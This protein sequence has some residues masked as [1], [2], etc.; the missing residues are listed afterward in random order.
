MP[1]KQ[2]TI[3]GFGEFSAPDDWTPQE[4]YAAAMNKNPAIREDFI[5]QRGEDTA[6][7][8]ETYAQKQQQARQIY[9]ERQEGSVPRLLSEWWGQGMSGLT[10]PVG[11]MG[12]SA[13]AFLHQTPLADTPVHQVLQGASERVHH[14]TRYPELYIDDASWL[15]KVARASYMPPD[16]HIQQVSDL[17]DVS[18][19]PPAMARMGGQV[20]ARIAV[21]TGVALAAKPLG[22]AAIPLVGKGA[23]ARIAAGRAT[24]AGVTALPSAASVA[25]QADRIARTASN[26]AGAGVLTSIVAPGMYDRFTAAGDDHER[27][28]TKTLVGA[29][30]VGSMDLLLGHSWRIAGMPSQAAREEAT[31]QL[32]GGALRGAPAEKLGRFKR[33]AMFDSQ[34]G[35]QRLG[36]QALRDSTVEMLQAFTEG[37]LEV[38]GLPTN[39]EEA[40][41]SATIS[42]LTSGTMLGGRMLATRE[43]R[44]TFLKSPHEIAQ[45]LATEEYSD[46]RRKFLAGEI[47]LQDAAKQTDTVL[48]W[49]DTVGDDVFTD[50]D[51]ASTDPS[52]RLRVLAEQDPTLAEALSDSLLDRFA[53]GELTQGRLWSAM[54]NMSEFRDASLAKFKQ[55]TG[56]RWMDQETFTNIKGMYAQ[57]KILTPAE[58]DM[59]FDPNRRLPDDWN[60]RLSTLF[61]NKE[62]GDARIESIKELLYHWAS[63]EQDHNYLEDPRGAVK[64]FV[65]DQGISLEVV[66]NTAAMHQQ[67]N[68]IASKTSEPQTAWYNPKTGRFRRTA[69]KKKK[70]EWKKTTISKL[71]EEH[72]YWHPAQNRAL[73]EAEARAIADK[74]EYTLEDLQSVPKAIRP[75]TM[76]EAVLY[77]NRNKTAYTTRAVAT[78]QEVLRPDRPIP[79]KGLREYNPLDPIRS[80]M[81]QYETGDKAQPLDPTDPAEFNS[82]QARDRRVRAVNSVLF[83]PTNS[84][85][86]ITDSSLEYMML[87]ST[88]RSRFGNSFDVADYKKFLV[89]LARDDGIRALQREIEMATPQI[90]VS[91]ASGIDVGALPYSSAS[92]SKAHTAKSIKA[93]DISAAAENSGYFELVIGYPDAAATE[94]PDMHQRAMLSSVQDALGETG[95]RDVTAARNAIAHVRGFVTQVNKDGEVFNVLHAEEVQGD[96]AKRWRE[97]K[98]TISE[99][100]A[101]LAQMSLPQ[102]QFIEKLEADLRSEFSNYTLRRGVDLDAFIRFAPE[103]YRP[104][105]DRINAAGHTHQAVLDSL[106]EALA[107]LKTLE[108]QI[109]NPLA[110]AFSRLSQLSFDLSLFADNGDAFMAATEASLVQTMQDYVGASEDAFNNY[111]DSLV[112]VSGYFHDNVISNL[113]TESHGWLIKKS[114]NMRNRMARMRS[115]H[116]PGDFVHLNQ[117]EVQDFADTL[118]TAVIPDALSAYDGTVAGIPSADIARVASKV[119]SLPVASNTVIGGL[120]SSLEAAIADKGERVDRIPEFI[121]KDWQRITLTELTRLAANMGLDGISIPQGYISAFAWDA[122]VAGRQQLYDTDL[123]NTMKSLTKR[124]KDAEF[125]PASAQRAQIEHPMYVAS[126]ANGVHVP[127]LSFRGE[128]FIKTTKDDGILPTDPAARESYL[129]SVSAL[130]FDDEMTSAYTRPEFI[131]LMEQQG[132]KAKKRQGLEG[133]LGAFKI[134]PLTGAKLIQLLEQKADITTVVHEFTHARLMGLDPS[135]QVWQRL[136]K[137]FKLPEDAVPYDL[138]DPKNHKL[139]EK[140]VRG[141]LGFLLNRGEA[142]TPGWEYDNLVPLYSFMQQELMHELNGIRQIKAPDRVREITENEMAL[143][144]MLHNNGLTGSNRVN[145]ANEVQQ[146]MNNLMVSQ[147]ELF[148]YYATDGP[149]RHRGINLDV[150]AQLSGLPKEAISDILHMYMSGV[151]S[152]DSDAVL[153]MVERNMSKD[154][155]KRFATRMGKIARKGSGGYTQADVMSLNTLWLI[156]LAEFDIIMSSGDSKK[157]RRYNE[158]MQGLSDARGDAASHAGRMLSEFRKVRQLELLEEYKKLLSPQEQVLLETL[159]LDWTDARQVVGAIQAF[160]PTDR[161]RQFMSAYAY[162]SMLSNP[163]TYFQNMWSN[164]FWQIYNLTL[165][166]LG[167]ASA[168]A[169]ISGFGTRR[170]RRIFAREVWNMKTP[171]VLAKGIKRGITAYREVMSGQKGLDEVVTKYG[172]EVGAHRT[173]YSVMHTKIWKHWKDVPKEQRIKFPWESMSI[174]YMEYVLRHLSA[175][176]IFGKTMSRDMYEHQLEH[177]MQ[178]WRKSGILEAEVTKAANE[179]MDNREVMIHRQA[180]Q[181]GMSYDDYRKAEVARWIANPEHNMTGAGVV[182]FMNMMTFHDPPMMLPQQIINFRRDADQLWHDIFKDL[183]G[184][185]SVPSAIAPVRMFAVPFISIISN[186]AVRSVEM[187]PVIGAL[188]TAFWGKGLHDVLG[189]QLAG[190]TL[191]F[192]YYSLYRAG[193][194]SGGL[195]EDPEERRAALNAGFIPY[196]LAIRNGNTYSYRRIP[197]PFGFPLVATIKAIET[198]EDVASD[199]D[200]QPEDVMQAGLEYMNDVRRYLIDNT[201]LD[202]LARFGDRGLLQSR[203]PGFQFQTFVPF[204]GFMRWS[205][206][207]W[208]SMSTGEIKRRDLTLSPEDFYQEGRFRHTGFLKLFGQSIPGLRDHIPDEVDVYGRTITRQKILEEMPEGWLPRIAD[209][210][211]RT[212][213][214]EPQFEK[215]AEMFEAEMRRLEMYPGMPTRSITVAGRNLGLSEDQYRQF[216]I[217]TGIDTRREVTRMIN[218]RGYQMMN[219]RPESQRIALDRM[220]RRV[221]DRARRRAIKDLDLVGVAR[222]FPQGA[223]VDLETGRRVDDIT[224][225]SSSVPRPGEW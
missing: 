119:E 15:G 145:L 62:F 173:M 33:W 193:M 136:V 106:T 28:L 165:G 22:L 60:K 181:A 168:D 54:R 195:P 124:F 123:G 157:I 127:R 186:I 44:Q 75:V 47:T 20:G 83:N 87:N 140:I 101:R 198:W 45:K 36:R 215:E 194:I 113:P 1:L 163:N 178:R 180:N 138:L 100:E 217:D 110:L 34:S 42:T 56:A 200:A 149:V 201:F 85:T 225:F 19:I 170:P 212:F 7:A 23:A 150:A 4:V 184:P 94:A 108:T 51:L 120:R 105:L 6:K 134:N 71:I 93:R 18:K 89:E 30:I 111:V 49:R 182:D 5:K 172:A 14:A 166:H 206:D 160:N 209:Q 78:M 169:I 3:E 151:S 43:G 224:E 218:T 211:W 216:V 142:R 131:T 187:T 189:K 98:R 188:P 147:E 183:P 46:T 81:V 11:A 12:R 90:Y 130:L 177:R 95:A 153:A 141:Y 213:T 58:L 74:G 171:K 77:E 192:I 223:I 31:R 70:K 162:S 17:T 155:R 139:H 148:E 129:R 103:Y 29:P 135:S 65:E 96:A 126:D 21:A 10:E 61:K 190:L 91:V 52:E 210:A 128:G 107:P 185:L 222:Q 179:Y 115:L 66:N 82:P 144:A 114:E 9:A 55:E 205:A 122:D 50:V 117:S 208:E 13:A 102:A 2:Y 221:R 37:A 175:A 79:K 84:A 121:N 167:E 26:I 164:S 154:Q 53:K 104:I 64:G 39:Y 109:N 92:A 196:S 63:K 137:D 116:S 112:E 156:G 32:V 132:K 133:T 24:K 202:T 25:K 99:L 16:R 27:A 118:I 69:P 41:I 152:Y 161:A 219:F 80:E 176:D 197:E 143:H 48:T 191:S 67:R 40:I 146:T 68:P 38:E 207:A 76:Q 125:V 174:H 220:L 158:M 214:R 199:P 97:N 57:G 86:Y 73:S 59:V 8:L 159:D 203:N 72:T 35:L 204:S 88:Q